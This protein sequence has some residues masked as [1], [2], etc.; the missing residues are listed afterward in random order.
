MEHIGAIVIGTAG[1]LR[2]ADGST[3]YE[4]RPVRV[5]D[6]A[7]IVGGTQL[8][9]RDGDSWEEKATARGMLCV[10]DAPGGLLVG[11]EGAH[12]LQ[13]SA[14]GLARVETFEQ[15]PGKE[16]WYTPWG[17]PP[18]TRSIA[19]TDENVLLVNVHVGGIA[20]SGDGGRS[21]SPT[22]DV[23]ADVHQ[24]VAV[25]GRRELAL[26]SAAVGLCRSTDG[27]TSW[28]VDDEGLHATYCRAVAVGGSSVYVS[29]SE[30]PRGRR[31]AIYRTALSGGSLERVTD[32][33][34]GNVDSGC[35]AARDD[36]VV[37]GTVDGT[38]M[39]SHDR[40]DSWSVVEKGLDTVLSVTLR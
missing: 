33:I 14:D 2:D 4:G 23:H 10:A 34:D 25:R 22:I 19:V 17:G 11:T 18:D 39:R 15:V 28:T 36:T 31:S 29:A 21:W 6:H 35:L 37:Y 24:V 9:W 26:A 20:R 5:F 7:A 32:W 8:V 40:G 13:L 1:G 38:V 27:G 30:G 16:E 12:L 3:A